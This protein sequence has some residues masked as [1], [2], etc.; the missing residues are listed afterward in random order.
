MFD[1]TAEARL[2][3]D[4]GG[5]GKD[6]VQR[7]LNETRACLRIRLAQTNTFRARVSRRGWGSRG[8]LFVQPAG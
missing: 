7:L 4:S 3:K 8:H 2:G 6:H 1:S 5:F